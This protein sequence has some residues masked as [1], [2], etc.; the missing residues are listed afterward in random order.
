M[1]LAVSRALRHG[2]ERTVTRNGLI[3]VAALLA[4]TVLFVG[5]PTVLFPPVERFSN[6]FA[7]GFTSFFG[8][9]AAMAVAVIAI[10]VFVSDERQQ[11]PRT[12]MRDRLGYAAANLFIGFLVTAVIFGLGFILIIPGIYL[13]VSLMLWHVYVAVEDKDFFDALRM[14][15]Q[16][17]AGHK[18]RL[19]ALVLGMEIVIVIWQ[20]VGVFLASIIQTPVVE[21]T[22]NGFFTSFAVVFSLAVIADAYRQLTV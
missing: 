12:F 18:W 10:R 14:S 21:V 9:V 5:V 6:L 1:A 15:W 19:F 11:V 2:F 17:T 13:F 16:T 7:V 20:G 3:L 4:I 8:F 22:V